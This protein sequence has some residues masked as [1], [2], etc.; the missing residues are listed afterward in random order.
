MAAAY[1]SD[2]DTASRL[3]LEADVLSFYLEKKCPGM[4]TSDGK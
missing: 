4:M 3:N 2:S 1:N